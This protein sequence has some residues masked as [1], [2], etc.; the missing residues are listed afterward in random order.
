MRFLFILLLG[1]LVVLALHYFFSGSL[2]F[3]NIEKERSV[4]TVYGGLQA[5]WSGVFSF[6]VA[7][8][9]IRADSPPNA[10]SKNYAIAK[11]IG[12]WSWRRLCWLGGGALF[13]YLALDDMMEIHE[14]VGFVLNRRV[15]LTGYWGESFNWII[16]FAPFLAA[17]LLV[18]AYLVREM[19]REDRRAGFFAT[20]GLAL[21][22]ASLAL[23]GVGGQ[24]LGSPLYRPALLL[25]ESIELI[26]ISFLL[27][28]LVKFW[29]GVIMR[30]FQT[31]SRSL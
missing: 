7:W 19:W 24:L 3:F 28:G 1:D 18:F 25:E 6:A 13:T 22:L 17:G 11:K 31:G 10:V 26:A 16:Y 27:A 8:L 29:Y 12:R 14:R 21:I 23:E 5:L 15:G 20:V 4:N 30:R 2:G 9:L